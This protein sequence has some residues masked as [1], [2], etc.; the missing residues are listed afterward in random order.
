MSDVLERYKKA[1][2]PLPPHNLSWR[3]YGAGLENLGRNGK[4]VRLEMPDIGP[5]ELL[6]R[7][8]AV[9][10]CFSDVKL[11][12]QGPKHPRVSGRDL[13]NDP[14]VPGHEASLTIVKVG[15]D[16]RDRFHV[17]ER[18]LIQAD[19]FYKGVSMAFGYVQRGALQQFTIIGREII[20]GDEGCYLLP[21]RGS[22]GY[23]EVALSEPWACVVAAYRITHRE[24]LK[25]RGTAW[26]VAAD[27][28]YAQKCSLGNVFSD[29]GAPRR[30]LLSGLSGALYDQLVAESAKRGFELI[31]VDAVGGG[32]S[33]GDTGGAAGA[34]CGAGGLEPDRLA[35]E[36]GVTQGFD[37]IVVLG[38]PA[39]EFVEQA[40]KHLA[41]GGIFAIIATSPMARRVQIDVGRVHY[42]GLHF[43]GTPSGSVADA[44]KMQRS[45]QLKDGGSAW[46]I[47]AGGPMGQMHAQV[48]VS[49][50]SGPALVLATDI[51]DERLS[52]VEARFGEMASAKGTRM[53]TLNPKKV[54]ST[55][56]DNTVAELTGSGKFDDVVVM[57]PVPALIEQGADFVAGGGVLNIF[58][59]VPR[60]TMAGLD[61]SAVYLNGTRW[62]GSSGSR[63]SDL[64][65]TLEQ[66]QKGELSPNHSV[67]AIGGVNAAAEGIRAVKEGL[68]PGK[69]VIF[70]QLVD[71]PL[72][73][74]PRMAEYLPNVAEKLTPAGMWTKEAEDELLRSH[75][76]L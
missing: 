1:D 27:P 51:D 17:G 61:I 20:D 5:G 12:S 16:L 55:E 8:D 76:K 38:V 53:V 19:V 13:L 64:Q 71:L 66:T 30:V 33:A 65:Y 45:S 59:G 3:L 52:E 21:V 63:I 70:P 49:G 10:L 73:P 11:I 23:A 41:N 32:R 43:V 57:V 9:G 54:D 62:V 67:A 4:P 72:I 29:E 56:F 18:Y 42:D 15:E 74:L 28:G 68:F 44:Y 46:I 39:P 50:T 26:F 58:A 24:A 31:D 37:D 48:S 2:Y 75:L 36:Y 34:G 22:D 40:S 14:T 47:G 7:V 6:A 35:G 69:I 60:G 25:P